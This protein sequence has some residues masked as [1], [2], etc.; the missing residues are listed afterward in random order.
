MFRNISIIIFLYLIILPNV[1]YAH[2]GGAYIFAL[3]FMFLFGM[4]LV[5]PIIS[6][7]FETLIIKGIFKSENSLGELFF[8]IFKSNILMNT[9]L[10]I[11]FVTIYIILINMNVSEN[12]ISIIIFNL[13]I[14]ISKIGLVFIILFCIT[15]ILIITL[16]FFKKNIIKFDMMNISKSVYYRRLIILSMISFIALLLLILIVYFTSNNLKVI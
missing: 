13:L 15:L 14:N 1:V 6:S 10:V 7:I 2:A 16:Y 8:N 5:V 4:F 11:L 9:V 12:G 3:S